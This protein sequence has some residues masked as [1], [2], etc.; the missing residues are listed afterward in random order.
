M[1]APRKESSS[2]L[3]TLRSAS[4]VRWATSAGSESAGSRSS[5]PRKR[6]PSG[7]SRNSSSTEE[8]PTAA[9]IASLS[10]SVRERK[11]IGQPL[12]YELVE[13]VWG[14][15]EVPPQNRRRGLA[16]ETWFPPRERA[17]GEGRSLF[18][19][20]LPV[21]GGVEQLVRLGGVGEAD[22]HEPALAVR[23]LVDRLG[24][25]DHL[26]VHLDD[27]AR[28]R[29]DHVRDGL[30]GFDLPVALVPGKRAAFVR[31][32]VVDD[33]AERVLGVPR[34]PERG[35]VP[36]DPGPVVLAVIPEVVGI[37]LFRHYGSSRV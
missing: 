16:G 14:N 10:E 13:E 24:L 17:E 28:Q 12:A 15:R 11:L 27:L 8:T 37:A 2:P 1:P 25:L 23:V 26:A 30:D 19:E 36:L 3:G 31:G 21:G 32:L 5:S 18:V 20:Q 7:M 22:L 6:T 9:S 33:L 35:R 4:S 34:D 29:R